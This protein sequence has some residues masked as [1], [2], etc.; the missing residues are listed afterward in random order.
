MYVYNVYVPS[1]FRQFRTCVLN[2]CRHEYILKYIFYKNPPCGGYITEQPIWTFNVDC[3]TRNN[4]S[5][6][7]LC[8]TLRVF[9]TIV[10]SIHISSFGRCTRFWEHDVVI[11]IGSALHKLDWV[12]TRVYYDCSEHPH[13][14]LRQMY[15]ILG[16]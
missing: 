13:K 5:Y 1:Y 10:P 2:L 6:V 4:R 15:K 9:I 8:V 16:A 3:V 14:F 12:A 11:A 7:Q